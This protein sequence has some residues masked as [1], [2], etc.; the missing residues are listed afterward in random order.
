MKSQAWMQQ[1]DE[2]EIGQN[3][4]HNIFVVILD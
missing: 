2:N 1:E 4:L 3:L